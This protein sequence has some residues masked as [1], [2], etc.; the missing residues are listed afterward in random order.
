MAINVHC[1]DASG[2]EMGMKGRG[3]LT[4]GKRLQRGRQERFPKRSRVNHLPVVLFLVQMERVLGT[5][6]PPA[7]A[8]LLANIKICIYRGP[9][10]SAG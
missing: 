7:P 5:A 9:P 6:E 8:I 4:V 1:T 3:K 2:I 10:P